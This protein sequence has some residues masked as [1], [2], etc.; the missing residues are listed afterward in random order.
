V[1][2]N[3][4]K[5]QF[6][7]E[8]IKDGEFESLGIITHNN[9]NQLTFIEDSKYIPIVTKKRNISCILTTKK[10]A[11]SVPKHF[12]VGVSNNPKKTFYEVHNHLAKNTDFYWK[13]FKSEISSS[14]KIHKTAYIAEKNVRIGERCEIGPNASILEGS[15]LENDV[16]IGPGSVVGGEGFQFI[17]FKKEIM[18]I[19][20][21]GGVS[22]H[23]R[24]HVQGNTCIDKAVFDGFTEIGE[25]TKIDNLIH[26]AHNVKIGKRC[27]II[28]L[29]M[30]GGSA[31]IDDDVWIGPASSI[32]PE[33]HIKKGAMISIG[34]VVT[35]DVPPGK[36]VTGNFAIDH[37]KFIA[38]IKSIS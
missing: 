12:N 8:I 3:E 20:H 34:S 33:V 36:R 37:D 32:V 6:S 10:L 7:L 14:S 19:T 15:L 23:N 29:S 17:R 18:P 1:K 25:D 9:P 31:I 5:N 16:V 28:A 24:V 4:L 35:K 30:I 27:L 13:Q 22:V 38:F 26:I 2:L 21:A 11:P